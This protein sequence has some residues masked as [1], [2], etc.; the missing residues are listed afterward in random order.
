MKQLKQLCAAVLLTLALALS[1]FAG[2][3]EYPGVTSQSTQPSATG[4]MDTPAVTSSQPSAAGEMSA[5]G[6]TT[7]IDP[8]TVLAL[9]LLQNALLLF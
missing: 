3:M 1:A 6:A 7:S 4:N 2:N 8:L 5:P 9:G